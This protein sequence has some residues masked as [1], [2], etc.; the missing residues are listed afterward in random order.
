M[1]QEP[2]QPS[3]R[4]YVESGRVAHEYD[5]YFADSALFAY[6]LALL[7]RW[8][9][10]P[11]RVL[12]LGCGSGRHVV[13]FARAGFDVTGVDLSPHMIEVASAKLAESNAAARLVKGDIV[14]PEGWGE[15]VPFDYALC[16][17]STFGLIAGHTNR[18]RALRN[19]HRLLRPG[20]LLAMHV[21]NR[22]HNLLSMQGLAYLASNVFRTLFGRSEWGDKYIPHY[23][24][25]RNMY[26]HVF[27]RRELAGLLRD[28]G[29]E[30]VELIGLNQ[31]RDGPA[32]WRLS[33]G[34][35]ANG[36]MVLARSVRSAAA[37]GALE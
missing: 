11:G 4:L 17:F 18:L 6:D 19:W 24:G 29:F 26:I 16:M 20:G 1:S 2:I 31:R 13:A 10:R 12:D 30:I 3:T 21:H 22:W 34:L 28:A 25:I 23:R 15:P 5:A 37:R 7:R 27:S 32:R 8:M 9:P 33:A 36:F 35:L 14:E